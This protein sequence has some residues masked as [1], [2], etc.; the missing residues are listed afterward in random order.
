[1]GQTPTHLVF[2]LKHLV[3]ILLAAFLPLMVKAQVQVILT[4]TNATCNGLCNGT[5]TA[6]GS[7]GWAPYTYVWSNGATTATISSLC[8]GTYSVT[9]TDIDQ[10]TATGSITITQPSQ[11]GVN[12]SCTSQICGNTPDGTAS[13]VP[14]GGIPPYTYLWNTG[15]NTPQITGLA[16]GTY[17]ATVTD[18]NGCTT[19]AS[20]NVGFWNEGIWLMDTSTN[21]T[22]YGY[23]NGTA[24]V[25][26]MS[27]QPPYTYIWSNGAT[28]QDVVGLA[29]GTYTVTVSDVNGCSNQRAVTITQPTQLVC[30]AT[31]VPMNCGLLGSA[32]ISAT[33]GTPAY[34]YL[35]SNGQTTTTISVTAG[36]Y[37]ATVTDANGCT[38]SSSVTV[39]NNSNNLTVTTTVNSSAGCTVGGSAT[40]TVTGGSGTYTFLWDN[41]QTTATATNLSAGQHVVTATDGASGCQGS[42]Q[43]NI[44]SAPPLSVSTAVNTN[45]TCNTGGS[46]TATPAGGQAPY[47]YDWSNDGPDNPDNDPQTVTGLIAGTYTVT[48]TDA[49]GCTATAT[50]VITQLQGPGV[51]VTVNSN[52]TCVTGGSATANATGTGPFTYHW[53]YNNINTAT[54]SDLPPGDYTVTVTDANGCMISGSAHISQTGA[55]TAV[56]TGSSP[57][58]CSNNTGSA[59]VGVTGGT[60]PYTYDWSNDGPDN[61]DNDAATVT[62]IGAG[63]YTVTVTDANGCTT[64]AQV[65]IA[66]SLPP[67]VVITASTNATC[68]SPGSATASVSGGTGP[69]TYLWSDMETTQTAVNLFAGTYTVT[70]TDAAQCTATASVT[71][72]STNNGISI[73]DYVWYDDDQDGFQHPTETHGVDGVTVTL[74]KAGPD[75]LFN[76]SDDVAIASTTTDINGIYHFNCVVPG[77]YVLKFSGIP[78]G[79]EWTQKN[80]P[81]NDCKDSDVN[82]NGKTDPFTIVAGQGNDF[83]FDAGIHIKC[84]NVTLPGT[85]CC[86]QTICEG[87][88]PALIYESLPPSGGSGALQYMWLQFISVGGAPPNW[89]SVP[90]AM[91][92][93]YQPGPLF[94]TTRFMRCVRRDGCTHWIESNYVEITVLP[95]GSP[96]CTGFMTNFSVAPHDPTSV[97]VSWN[98]LPEATE[99][100]YTVQH[101]TN[102]QQ[103]TNIAN[104]MGKQ[105]AVN[106]NSYSYLDETPSNGINY[107]RIKRTTAGGQIA[108]SDPRDITLE[109]GTLETVRITPNPV[110]SSL[111]IMNV[112]QFDSDITIEITTTD[113][114]LLKTL[115]M[116][117]NKMNELSVDMT[118]YPSAIYLVRVHLPDGSRKTYKIAK[119]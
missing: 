64:T 93:S 116:E 18:A 72:G 30:T 82:V 46:A 75:G 67:T 3:L 44:P 101:S 14:Y 32:T 85:I 79:Y 23:N 40:A 104:V 99:Y 115:T 55:P 45:A 108:F 110:V 112:I 25:S 1:M 4:G 78:S 35:W 47:T 48:V 76:T 68:S 73:G 17:T 58:S 13:A 111:K 31:S 41:G 98:T 86:N 117:K 97:Q 20:C 74:M 15:A 81:A 19:A 11:L 52:A 80:K 36:T 65:S 27:G 21:V 51:T 62:G 12:V 29:P 88:T 87:E 33:G 56:I 69:Y 92:A 59:T 24:H 39:G 28:T 96:G 22:C 107:Y 91:S 16:A 100:L 42:G 83:C 9:V 37:T 106:T 102:S 94:E 105:D 71:I 103:W 77:T 2:R 118:D 109:F 10:G 61:P 84:D 50:V 89:V 54:A 34:S 6:L 53:S 114:K 90:G 95:A 66:S 113:G 7:G 60:G 49:G 63:T 119:I 5:A 57:S 8:A 26:A 70:V 38:C 43:V